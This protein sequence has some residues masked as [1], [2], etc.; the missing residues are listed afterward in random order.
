MGTV[1]V[2]WAHR[3]N[4]RMNTHHS[5]WTDHRAK[6]Q[7]TGS[8]LLTTEHKTW[9]LASPKEDQTSRVHCAANRTNSLPLIGSTLEAILKA[10]N[11]LQVGRL[12][13]LKR[14]QTEFLK[15]SIWGKIWCLQSSLRRKKEQTFIR[16]C[17]KL[18]NTLKTNYNKCWVDVK[19][20]FPSNHN[21]S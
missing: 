18:R 9:Q 3:N 14:N 20:S 7:I 5:C 17:R 10:L 8:K 16:G 1:A 12:T 19:S 6:E 13:N 2:W 21:G 15:L 4:N 11:R